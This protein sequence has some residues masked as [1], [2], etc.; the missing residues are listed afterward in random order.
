SASLNIKRLIDGFMAYAHGGILGKVHLQALRDLFRAPSRRPASAFPV[1]GP[2]LLPYHDGSIEND[3][4]GGGDPT[5]ESILHVV[6]QGRIVGQLAGLRASRCAI[7]MP[8]CSESPVVE[9]SSAGCRV[10]PD[11]TGDRAGRPRQL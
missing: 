11:L 9:G 8:L 2:P 10:A 5:G 3:T 4:L 1:N 7:R 6:A